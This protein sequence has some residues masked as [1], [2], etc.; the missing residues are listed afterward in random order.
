MEPVFCDKINGTQ[1][2]KDQVIDYQGV[3]LRSKFSKK[4]VF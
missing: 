4:N 1:F 3:P 2:Y